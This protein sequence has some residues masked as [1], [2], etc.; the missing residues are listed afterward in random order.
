MEISGIW[1]GKT[2]SSSVPKA[3]TFVF[4]SVCS[5]VP[6]NS[7][8]RQG[9][10]RWTKQD[11]A[12]IENVASQI[13]SD[14]LFN[15]NRLTIPRIGE[16]KLPWPW[17]EN[18]CP[19]DADWDLMYLTRLHTMMTTCNKRHTT[20]ESPATLY[21][22]NIV[23]WYK[24]GGKCHFFGFELTPLAGHPWALSI[25]R[26]LYQ[27]RE[28]GSKREIK[29]G[30]AMYS[31]FTSLSP[32]SLAAHY[33]L[34]RRTIIY[35]SWRANVIRHDF[36]GGNNL[37]ELLETAVLGLA[38][39]KTS[40][41]EPLSEF[42]PDIQYSKVYKK[43]YA[44]VNN[45]SKSFPEAEQ[46]DDLIEALSDK[47]GEI[48]DEEAATYKDQELEIETL[49]NSGDL[50]RYN[51][52]DTPDVWPPK[53]YGDIDARHKAD[54]KRLDNIDSHEED[55]FGRQLQEAGLQEDLVVTEPEGLAESGEYSMTGAL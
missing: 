27:E 44:W 40:W 17:A 26:G 8:L 28:D 49:K 32:T 24:T 4:R 1:D 30:E 31:G 13:E 14:V 41:Y 39:V 20:E 53:T 21:L 11:H 54:I 37:L 38:S 48:D 7:K 42:Y 16:D 43:P 12:N 35:E 23:Q 55:K 46:N 2:M 50:E 34:T 6:K 19:D 33:K 9:F 10:P 29:A 18:T 52:E 22:E 5:P 47:E 25:G 51:V 45:F 15:P 36:P 3:K